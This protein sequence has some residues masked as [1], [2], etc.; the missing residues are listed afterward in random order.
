MFV[1]KSKFRIDPTLIPV[2]YA[3]NNIDLCFRL[4]ILSILLIK[5]CSGIIIGNFCSFL[6]LVKSIFKYLCPRTF[7]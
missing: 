1:V 2:E 3:S 7:S 4:V 5:C 6:G